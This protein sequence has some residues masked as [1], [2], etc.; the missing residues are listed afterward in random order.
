MRVKV[1]CSPH[2]GE[3]EER[4][5]FPASRGMIRKREIENEICLVPSMI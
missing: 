5:L 2:R 4:R 1:D 3:R